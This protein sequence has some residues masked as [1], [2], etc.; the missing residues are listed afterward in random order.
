MISQ[1]CILIEY[2]WRLELAQVKVIE[3]IHPEAGNQKVVVS[4]IK[5]SYYKIIIHGLGC[6][7]RLVC[8]PSSIDTAQFMA[9]MSV[10]DA[11]PSI[12]VHVMWPL[13]YQSIGH[14]RFCDAQ[15]PYT[16]F[17]HFFAF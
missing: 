7:A 11:V 4:L 13:S 9:Y 6:V 16:G 15:G 3:P 10:Q 5:I 8:L 2:T 1:L 17:M 12:S 14:S